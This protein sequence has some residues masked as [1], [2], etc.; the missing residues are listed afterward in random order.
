MPACVDLTGHV[1]SRLKV[2]RRG[3]NLHKEI[4][5]LCECECG[6]RLLVQRSALRSGNTQSCGCYKADVQRELHTTHGMSDT[7]E[8]NSYKSMIQRCTSSLHPAY[9]EYGGR[10][11]D[12][13]TKWLGPKGFENFYADMGERPEGAELDRKNTNK[14]YT[15]Q[16]C[17]WATKRENNNNKRNNVPQVSYNG[18]TQPVSYWAEEFGISC[19]TL[20]KRLF[21]LGWS[22]HDSLTRPVRKLNR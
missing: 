21:F 20:N 14:G 11:I 1:F 12:V 4:R 2:L 5:W 16:N 19:A 22:V 7:P 13:C 6:T 3:P 17:R 18:V 15:K 8:Y 10:G 9:E